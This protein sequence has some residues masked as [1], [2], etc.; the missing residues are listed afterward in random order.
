MSI[1]QIKTTTV[2]NLILVPSGYMNLNLCVCFNFLVL[3]RFGVASTYYGISLNI[4]GFGLNMYLT[5]F[6]YAAIEVPAKLMI[7]FLLNIIGRRKCQSGTLLLTGVCIAINIFLPKGQNAQSQ[8]SLWSILEPATRGQARYFSL[9]SFIF[10]YSSSS[11]YSL[12]SITCY[13]Q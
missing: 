13:I 1:T 4:G 11:V 10:I 7:Y 2:P 12:Q 3:C 6:I 5:H 9:M 8:S